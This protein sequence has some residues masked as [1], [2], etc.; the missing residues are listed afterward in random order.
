MSVSRCVSR[1]ME[2]ALCTPSSSRTIASTRCK[3]WGF[4]LQSTSQRLRTRR[5]WAPV[6]PLVSFSGHPAK[7]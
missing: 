5:F 2:T 1:V 6:G 7:R 4:S 3:I